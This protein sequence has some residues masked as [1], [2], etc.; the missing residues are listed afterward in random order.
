MTPEEKSV[1]LK[2]IGR[3][4][5]VMNIIDCTDENGMVIADVIADS[6]STTNPVY[7]RDINKEYFG[8]FEIGTSNVK[9]INIGKNY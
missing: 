3:M 2:K 4:F 6:S 1:I 7:S 8:T 9:V 5:P